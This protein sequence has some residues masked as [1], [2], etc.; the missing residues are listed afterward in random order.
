MAKRRKPV[1]WKE[2]GSVLLEDESLMR[3][4]KNEGS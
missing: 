3:R 4:I 1:K 2:K